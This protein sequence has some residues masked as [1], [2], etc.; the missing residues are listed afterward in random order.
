MF[1]IRLNFLVANISCR[2]YFQVQAFKQIF[3]SQ[4]DDNKQ[5]LE[6]L[7]QQN[8]KMKDMERNLNFKEKLIADFKAKFKTL[9]FERNELKD[10]HAAQLAK[11]KADA[12]AVN[13][14]LKG[15][16]KKIS[17]LEAKLEQL[18]EE[19]DKTKAELEAVKKQDDKVAYLEHMTQA[20]GAN[21]KALKMENKA[22]NTK[23]EKTRY[24]FLTFSLNS[25]KNSI[26]ISSNE[27]FPL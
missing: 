3:D 14:T 8:N 18:R 16:D 13:S 20:L 17:N 10:T 12:K 6:T 19:L 9:D 25:L 24:K 22:L 15:K 26:F 23:I 4:R 2:I 21:N 7:K 1:L 11:M 5:L 27:R